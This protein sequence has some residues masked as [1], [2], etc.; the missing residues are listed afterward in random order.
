MT[1]AW[2]QRLMSREKACA[3]TA[4]WPLL[5][6][7]APGVTYV[8]CGKCTLAMTTVPAG[9]PVTHD[10]LVPA[11]L[12]H[13]VMQHGQALN[14]TGELPEHAWGLYIDV[15]RETEEETDGRTG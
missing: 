1:Q 7:S 5:F 12:R 6:S 10:G 3:L 11:I 4:D 15:S 13:M 8:Q 2:D 9:T 14:V